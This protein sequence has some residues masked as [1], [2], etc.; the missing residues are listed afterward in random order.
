MK[1][2]ILASAAVLGLGV[3]TA[4][5]ESEGGPAGNTYFTELPGVLAQAPV[6]QVTG[7]VAQGQMGAPLATFATTHSS[8]TWQAPPSEGA[9]N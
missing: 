5:A 9:N 7:A 6:Q 1:T 4:F 3:T 8:Q 2:I